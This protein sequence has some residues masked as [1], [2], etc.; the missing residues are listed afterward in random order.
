MEPYIPLLVAAL[1]G[2]V[3]AG[4]VFWV[5]TARGSGGTALAQ[6][7]D[8]AETR[9]AEAEQARGRLEVE[10]GILR[11]QAGRLP[12]LEEELQDRGA[13]LLELSREQSALSARTAAQAEDLHRLRGTLTERERDLAEV[14]AEAGRLERELGLTKETARQREENDRVRIE[15]LK[16]LR[17][18]MTNRFRTLSDE[19]LRTQGAEFGKQNQERVDALLKPMK[20]RLESYTK[21][22]SEANKQAEIDRKQMEREIAR[23]TQHSVEMSRETHNL[24]QALKGQTQT[25]GA[26]GEMILESILE[27]SGLREGEEYRVQASHTDEAGGRVRPDVIVDIPGGRRVVLDSKVSLVAF[28]RAVGAEDETTRAKAMNEH[29][30]SLRAHIKG[31]GGKSYQHVADSDLDYV[32]MFVPIEGAFAAALG[33]DPEL[34]RFA[35]ENNVAIATPTTLMLALRTIASVWQVERRSRNADE[36]ARQAGAL[37]DKFVGF[38]DDMEAIGKQLD[39]TQ[40]VYHDAFGKL[41]KGRGNLVNRVQSLK[42]L[43]AKTAKSL[44][45]ALMEEIDAL[46]APNE[47]D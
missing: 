27:R 4:I 43:G 16:Q 36:I 24:T 19:I 41:S 42:T 33:A 6:R 47:H 40:S 9:L 29:V 5:A 7:L 28:E 11:A 17:E 12:A 39:R 30:A 23:L 34:T 18:D 31:L 10:L 8:T 21:E 38:V 22:L 14:R 46:P 20:E 32:I 44:P 13:R 37:Y 2:V 45:D 1:G 26:W 35:V 15:E 25:Q 3:I